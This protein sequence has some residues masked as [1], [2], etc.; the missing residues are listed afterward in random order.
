[1]SEWKPVRCPKCGCRSVVLKEIWHSSI[2]LVQREDGTLEQPSFNLDPGDPTGEIQATC[3]G[4]GHP[5]KLK[6]WRQFPC[7]DAE[8]RC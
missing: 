6:G 1:M 4:C 8:E 3:D 7:E 2:T 5:W